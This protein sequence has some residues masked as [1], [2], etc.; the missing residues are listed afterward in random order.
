[1]SSRIRP[2]EEQQL[3]IE[4]EGSHALVSA[5]AGAGK[6]TTLVERIARLIQRGVD[7]RK[8]MAIQYNKSAQLEMQRKLQARM[9][10][11]TA[12][13]A[14]TFHSLGFGMMKRLV[15]VGALAPA[16][17]EPSSAAYD[18]HQRESLK[19]EWK[20][21]HGREAF[22]TQQ[23][24]EGF[25]Q[26]VT[27]T[28]ADTKPAA[29]IFRNS[30]FGIECAPYVAAIA[31]MDATAVEQGICYFDDLL[32]RANQALYDDPDLWSIFNR[33]YSHY[34]VDEFQDVNPVQYALLQG[35]AGEHAECM[36][37]GD[38]DQSIYGFRGSDPK[39][40][41]HDFA[42]DF[43]PCAKFK[44]QNTFRYGHETALAAN[45]LITRN[46]DR[47]DKI[48][49]ALNSNPDT[50][51]HML[52]QEPKK[53]SGVVEKLEHAHKEQRLRQQAILVR[54][55]SQS[56]PLEIELATAQIP[57]FV[58]GREPLLLVPEIA[59][60]VAALCLAE[61]YWVIPDALRG[62]YLNAMISTPTLY[63]QKNVV[64]QI[65]K[66]MTLALAD[67]GPVAPALLDF[68]R[69]SD[70]SAK[71]AERLRMRGD[72]IRLLE[73]GGLRN[74]EPGKVIHAYLAFT[75]AK[76]T[77]A[78]S[79]AT[80]SQAIEVDQNIN[81]FVDMASRFTTT[82]DLLNMLG[83]LAAHDA[84]SPPDEDHL[85]I[86][87][88]H[89]AKG[90]EW[91]T[92]FLPGWAAKNFPRELESI[93]EER[94]LAYVAI[95]R[96][97][98]NLV[99]LHPA[100]ST[101]ED[102]I[103]TIG[104]RLG[105]KGGGNVLASQFLYEAEVGLARA[106]RMGIRNE[107]PNHITGRRSD[108]LTRYMAESRNVHVTSS[109]PDHLQ[110]SNMQTADLEDVSIIPG[111]SRLRNGETLYLVTGTAGVSKEFYTVRPISGGD[112]RLISISEPGWY[113]A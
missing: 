86:G 82:R 36:V 104:D 98:K 19:A 107:H 42:K 1:M 41:I 45:H 5:V 64:E 22:P 61:D 39:F 58:Y 72:V 34:V 70:V 32:S 28:K 20:R 62:R 68:A 23:Q 21:V 111:T 96:A 8:I 35:L 9:E 80:P 91:D 59:M 102:S 4:H 69:R 84:L 12:P 2:T 71:L 11:L 65:G 6:S 75:E 85:F 109:V 14:R 17:L 112:P 99:F 79:A 77:L 95:T 92:V 49:V 76:D 89:R 56:I 37:V 13:Q 29:E 74:K 53:P 18:R 63:A 90:M 47:D 46:L 87:S 78:R 7:P 66:K 103:T 110:A 73:A 33:A 51:I 54:Y 67:G 81:A 38:P 106:G 100:D 10:G 57:F 25:N 88:L 3:V 44:L 15:D 108:V 94:R 31:R 105:S 30:E 93:E 26:F 52:R 40:I 48:T 101:L 97:I 16:R 83:P 50:R 113:L 43:T 60:L 24:M 27:R 55:Y